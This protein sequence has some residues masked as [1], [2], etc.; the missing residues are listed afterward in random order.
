MCLSLDSSVGT[1]SGPW[2]DSLGRASVFALQGD[3]LLTAG[4][5]LGWESLFLQVRGSGGG[6]VGGEAGR[7]PGLAP[8]AVGATEEGV[9][10]AGVA[11][12][13]LAA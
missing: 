8:R 6:C 7:N 11:G 1:G 3:S 4:R 5:P 2:A 13:T 10:A 12:V 9:R